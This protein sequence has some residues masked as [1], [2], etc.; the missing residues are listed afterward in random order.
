MTSYFAEACAGIGL[1]RLALACIA[2]TEVLTI[3]LTIRDIRGEKNK[4]L[5]PPSEAV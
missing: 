5:Y 2:S 1:S 3:M 4:R